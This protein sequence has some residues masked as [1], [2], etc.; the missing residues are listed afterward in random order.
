MK[1][2]LI[3]G[4]DRQIYLKNLLEED[5]HEVVDFALTGEEDIDLVLRGAKAVILPLPAFKDGYLN[6]PKSEEK[7]SKD[8]IISKTK[9]CPIVFGGMTDLEFVHDYY[10]RPELIVK[11]AFITAQCACALMQEELK[12]D[13]CGMK[14]LIT[15]YGRIGKFLAF[16]MKSMGAGV[17]VSSRKASVRTEAECFGF[18]AVDTDGIEKHISGFD[19]VVNTVPSQII[20]EDAVKSS[21]PECVFM[22]LASAP[23]GIDMDCCKGMDR[24]VIFAPG[25]P[26]KMMPAGAAK[27][28]KD[29]IY[30]MMEEIYE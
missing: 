24:K 27:A 9:S 10:K 20:G 1:I 17:T 25:L 15:G 13:L 7:Y 22:E 21:K 18:S 3:G 30:N 5:G 23:Y 12:K 14:I 29:T 26:G 6:A 16:Q 2:A 8:Y 4:D 28:M 11:N 19:A